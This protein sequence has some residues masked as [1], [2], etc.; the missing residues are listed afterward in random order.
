[1][2]TIRHKNPQTSYETV[3]IFFKYYG[4]EDCGFHSRSAKILHHKI[5]SQ[6]TPFR[7]DSAHAAR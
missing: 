7:Y 1:M 5:V 2:A 4:R 6:F 3:A